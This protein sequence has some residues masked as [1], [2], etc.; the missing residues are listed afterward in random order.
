MAWKL[1]SLNKRPGLLRV[2]HRADYH[3]VLLDAATTSGVE[4]RL[5]APVK[6]INFEKTSV[7]VDGGQIMSANVIVGADG[8]TGDLAYRA[9][10]KTT[11]LLALNDQQVTEL[12]TQ[13]RCTLWMGPNKHCVLYPL[14]GG[15][16]FNLV[17]IRPDNLPPGTNKIQGEIGEMRETFQGWDRSL[18]KIISRIPS[19]L[20]WKLCFHNELDTWYKSQGNV[21]LLGDAC[22]PTLPYQAQGAAMAIEDG[23]VLGHLLGSLVQDQ[24]QSPDLAHGHVNSLLQVY[25][26]LR[27]LRTTTNVKGA[28]ANRYMFHLED[29]DEQR[30]RD[31]ELKSHDWIRPSR[32]RW[33]DGAAQD[34][35]LGHDVIAE[36]EREYN[37]WRSGITHRL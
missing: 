22:H 11:D 35:L 10:L 30:R 31:A 27:K 36:S 20:K 6:K 33:A 34:E 19:V 17:L 29:G 32:W 28:E 26:K 3:Q 18:T 13:K 7:E 1:S 4:I 24:K 8:E 21:T 23:A 9:T 25:E 37:A 16:E 12:C 14:K 5:G 2:I 15:S